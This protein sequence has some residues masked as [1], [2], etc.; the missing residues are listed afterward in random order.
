M[1]SGSYYYLN[2]YKDKLLSTAM[3]TS[4]LKAF[5]ANMPELE[6][7]GNL[8][9]K[10]RKTF[11]FTRI[12]LLNAKNVDSWNENDTSNKETNL[13]TIVCVNGKVGNWEKLENL[14]IKIASFLKWA[15][16]IEDGIEEFENQIIW[17]PK[18]D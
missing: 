4:K 6:K 7:N 2:I 5:L 3:S 10:N 14:F 16:V 13:I 18:E 11:P 15:I 9:F 12:M 17:K 1:Q 8:G